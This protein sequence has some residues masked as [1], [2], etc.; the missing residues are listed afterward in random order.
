MKITSAS[1]PSYDGKAPHLMC[2]K[3]DIAK[4]VLLPGDPGRVDLFKSLFDEFSIISSNREYVVGTGIYKGVPISVCSTG[5][6]APST[7]IAVV[8]LVELGAEVL[9]RV[10]GTGAIQENINCG[11]FIINTGAVRKGGTSNF[12]APVE[13]PAISSFEVTECLLETCKKNN[14]TTWKGICASVGSF[15]AGQGRPAA[16]IEFYNSN[17]IENYRKLGILNLEMES[18]TIM[19]LGSIFNVLTGSICAVH[20]NRITDEW[21]VDFEEI[22]LELCK[23]AL[24]SMVVLY[25]RYL[26]EEEN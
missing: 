8:E 17:L 21:V 23:V 6:G 11:D 26:K 4:I 19:T 10:G 9:I 1:S 13:F 20:C 14:L 2:R 18:E 7:E 22:Q 3:E 5:I 16:G 24:D 12:Y 15:F 25:N